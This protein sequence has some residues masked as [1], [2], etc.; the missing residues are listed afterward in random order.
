MVVHSRNDFSTSLRDRILAPIATK[1]PDL[2]DPAVIDFAV[3][4]QAQRI[5][6]GSLKV[7]KARR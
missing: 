3:A 5:L 6:P 4:T 2:D 1:D 7:V